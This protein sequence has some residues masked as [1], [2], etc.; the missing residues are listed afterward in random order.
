[1]LEGPEGQRLHRYQVTAENDF[2]RAYNGFLK[3]RAQEEALVEMAPP[4]PLP[5]EPKSAETTDASNSDSKTSVDIQDS[6]PEV[7]GPP[8]AGPGEPLP[9]EPKSALHEPE[10]VRASES[11]SLPISPFAVGIEPGTLPASTPTG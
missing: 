4:A 6:Y 9:N 10:E 2:H 8:P 3:A 5:N 7:E 1:M 11:S